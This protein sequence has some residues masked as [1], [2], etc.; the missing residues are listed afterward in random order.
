MGHGYAHAVL[1]TSND[2]RMIAETVEGKVE[3]AIRC[4]GTVNAR[5]IKTST[6]YTCGSC[7][8]I[9]PSVY[10]LNTTRTTTA[11]TY[12]ITWSNSRNDKITML[13]GPILFFFFFF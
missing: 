3:E 1:M 11:T 13:G 7:L 2:R 8:C 10:S 6:Q 12:V 5:P 9:S 4:Q